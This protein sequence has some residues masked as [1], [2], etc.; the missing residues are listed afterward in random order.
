MADEQ[1]VQNEKAGTSSAPDATGLTSESLQVPDGYLSQDKV[2]SLLAEERRKA[3]PADYDDLLAF[4]EQVEREQMT[5]QQRL[6]QERANLQ[7]QLL[8]MQRQNIGLA[9]GLP[10]ELAARIQGNTPEEMQADAEALK[11]L[12]PQQQPAT[13]PAPASTDATT[14]GAKDDSGVAGLN[15]AERNIAQAMGYSLEQYAELKKKR[16][17]GG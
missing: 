2:N 15:D 7:S 10:A 5:E 4:K 1:N 6:E 14:Q 8:G 17:Q 3:R 13:K 11:A 16:Q 9:A 12:L